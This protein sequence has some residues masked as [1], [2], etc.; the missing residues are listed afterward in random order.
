MA[1][2]ARERAD[3]AGSCEHDRPDPLTPGWANV[4]GLLATAAEGAQLAAAELAGRPDCPGAL[5]RAQ[6]LHAALADLT[7]ITRRLVIDESLLERVRAEAY[8]QGAADCK[9][10]RCRLAA[11]PGPH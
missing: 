3:L 8:A 2:P 1:E 7:E 11:V 10:A 5:R 9:A 4:R 6:L